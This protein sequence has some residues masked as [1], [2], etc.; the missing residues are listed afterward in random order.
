MRFDWF[1]AASPTAR[2]RAIIPDDLGDKVFLTK[3]A[4]QETFHISDRRAI[5]MQ[6]ER[7]IRPQNAMHFH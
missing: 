1:L 5:E 6:I 4:V 2:W 7:P 3:Y